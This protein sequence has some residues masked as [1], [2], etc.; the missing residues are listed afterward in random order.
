MAKFAPKKIGIFGGSFSPVHSGHV[1]LAKLA[2]SELNL[3]RVIFVPSFHTPLK[4]GEPL[5]PAAAR[6]SWIRKAIR[7]HR[8]LEVSDC[9]IRRGGTSYTVDTLRYFRRRFGRD[10]TLY[11]LAGADAEKNLSRW[12]SWGKV[13]KLCR[14]VICSR[15]RFSLARSQ[16]GIHYMPL[17]TPDISSSQVRESLATGV[18]L[19]ELVP[20][21][22]ALAL[23]KYQRKV[24]EVPST[25]KR[26]SR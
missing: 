12:K 17:A 4:K 14:F 16:S 10:A 6:I 20:P 22:V 15:P 13:L 5:Y 24:R 26:K 1:K 23:K 2:A 3:D 9:E 8:G 25:L 18:G 21:A 19:R 11:F 7:G